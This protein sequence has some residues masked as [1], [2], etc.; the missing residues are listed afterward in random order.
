MTTRPVLQF[1]L[2]HVLYAWLAASVLSGLP[3]TLHALAT[4]GDVMEATRAAALMVLP[5]DGTTDW[6]LQA[7]F[8]AA[9]LAHGSISLFWAMLLALVLPRRGVTAWA[10]AASA[11]IA[12]L[13][14]GL[15]APALFP[16][17]AALAFL[18]QL[19]DHLMWGACYGGTLAWMGRMRPASS[20]T[21]PAS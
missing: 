11:A 9:G 19:A 14:L 12:L 1:P 3:S 18:P 8:L 2:R 7:I 4:G 13:D 10:M 20:G 21:L 5:D 17:V 6:S 15:I 16:A